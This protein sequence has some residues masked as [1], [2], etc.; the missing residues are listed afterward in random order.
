MRA[1]RDKVTGKSPP[2]LRVIITQRN[3]LTRLQPGT[4][5]YK[6]LYIMEKDALKWMQVI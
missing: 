4:M 6:I 2:P 5:M 3:H 1:G